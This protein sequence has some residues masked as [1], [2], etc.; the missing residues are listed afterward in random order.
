LAQAITSSWSVAESKYEINVAD[1]YRTELSADGKSVQITI[2]PS[3]WAT[4]SGVL[5]D[6]GLFS[7]VLD[8]GD[9]FEYDLDSHSCR[10]NGKLSPIDRYQEVGG[11][12]AG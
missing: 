4:R 6:S 7:G 3:R 5:Q 11:W 8:G 10:I 1:R 12:T 2:E 9:V